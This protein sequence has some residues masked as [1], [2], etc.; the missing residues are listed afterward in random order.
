MT[1]MNSEIMGMSK[2]LESGR[3]KIMAL[4]NLDLNISCFDINIKIKRN[5]EKHKEKTR[6]KEGGFNGIK[7]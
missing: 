4:L 7:N 5:E 2:S 1:E 6:E 3:N